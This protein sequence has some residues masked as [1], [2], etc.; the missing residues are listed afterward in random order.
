M[1]KLMGWTEGSGLGT[2]GDGRVDP[3][4]T[5]IYA[6]GAGLGAS[7]GKEVGKYTDGYSGY[8]H[9]AKDAARER[10]GN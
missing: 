8:V 7:K 9:M 5:A 1:L 10:Y 3:V 4:Q 6:S 2:E